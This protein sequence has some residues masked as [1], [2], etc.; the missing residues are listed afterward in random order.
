[1]TKTET[2][3]MWYC[4]NTGTVLVLSEFVKRVGPIFGGSL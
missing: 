1:M 4:T 3:I 2:G